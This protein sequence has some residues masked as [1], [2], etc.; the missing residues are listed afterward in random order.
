MLEWSIRESKP[1]PDYSRSDDHEVVLTL[2]GE[3]RDSSFLDFLEKIS[4]ETLLSFS[5]Q[6]F[7]VVDLIY[8]EQPLLQEL[9]DR[10]PRLIELGVI[11]A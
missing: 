6:D 7:M 4:K 10:L 3:V 9:H 11:E 1:R 2:R 8:Q 5:T